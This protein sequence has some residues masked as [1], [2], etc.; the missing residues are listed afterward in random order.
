MMRIPAGTRRWAASGLVWAALAACG[1]EDERAPTE[2][3]ANV[4]LDG[5][6][7][8]ATAYV[9]ASIER[10]QH[11]VVEKARFVVENNL[12][13]LR[14]TGCQGTGERLF[15][16]NSPNPNRVEVRHGDAVDRPFDEIEM[17]ET[18]EAPYI[19][20]CTEPVRLTISGYMIIEFLSFSPLHY[21][22]EMP[23]A[24]HF[25]DPADPTDQFRGYARGMTYQ[26]PEDFGNGAILDVTTPGSLDMPVTP[27]YDLDNAGQLVAYAGAGGILDCLLTNGVVTITGTQRVEER[28]QQIL[29]VEDLDLRYAY[30]PSTTPAFATWPGGGYS[31]AALAPAGF[32]GGVA[33]STPVDLTFDGFGKVTFPVGDRV[34]E[35]SLLDPENGNPCADI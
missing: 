12:P 10:Y 32:L 24:W 7:L 29:L 33:I 4:F 15:L 21:T 26:L 13:S 3:A 20:A 2:L 34:C 18:P 22:V 19:A 1:C 27:F 25:P 9:T 11:D 8:F 30:D 35:G 5:D 31:I 14:E 16:R 23:I 28:V 17:D 6:G